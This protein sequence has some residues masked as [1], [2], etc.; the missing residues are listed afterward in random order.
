MDNPSFKMRGFL[1]LFVIGNIYYY[2][3]EGQENNV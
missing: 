3:G 1:C 2:N